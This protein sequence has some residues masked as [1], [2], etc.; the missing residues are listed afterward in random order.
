[1]MNLRKKLLTPEGAKLAKEAAEKYASDGTTNAKEKEGGHRGSYESRETHDK[2]PFWNSKDSASVGSVGRDSVE[3]GTNRD[4]NIDN[5]INIESTTEEES[6][7]HLEIR[8]SNDGVSNQ[9]VVH[10]S[11]SKPLEHP[12]PSTDV[13]SP[14]TKFS[15]YISSVMKDAD[16]I[17][18]EDWP[19]EGGGVLDKE[20]VDIR[21]SNDGQLIVHNSS[22]KPLE[23]PPPST[24]VISP[25][26]KFS[27]YI[28]S[29]M[30]DADGIPAEDWP[31]EGGGVL[32]KEE[33]DIRESNDG[34]LIVHNSS[35]K[36]LEHPPLST[37]VISPN[38]KFS[39]YISSVMK[40]ADGIPQEDWQLG[41]ESSAL[42]KEKVAKEKPK[43]TRSEDKTEKQRSSS[44][45]L[46]KKGGSSTSTSSK[47][48]SSSSA[49]KTKSSEKMKK[50]K[51]EKKTSSSSKR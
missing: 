28:S 31:L 14:N 15:R 48:K 16:G 21:E 23:H 41:E 2:D 12:P 51:K 36:P 7:I 44:L 26:T 20:E 10:K 29:V 24:D 35:S 6:D 50:S 45:K 34:Q 47:T 25:N 11:S 18:A 38:T 39:R 9:L 49:A 22:S 27:R 46:E 43:R 19:L 13:I 32:D 1:M 4:S 30:K 3:L 8:E 42:D 17:P 37:D 40:D 33:V 5:K